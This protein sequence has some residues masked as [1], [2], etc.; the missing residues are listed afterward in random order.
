MSTSL[1]RTAQTE[2]RNARDRLLD[3]ASNLLSERDNLEVSL[4][5]ISRRSG[6]N[7]G[8]VNYYFGGKEGLLTALL[9]R[10][11]L[12]SLEGL[13]RL[14]ASDLPPETKLE[15]HIRGVMQTYFRFPYINRLINHLQSESSESAEVLARMF[16]SPLQVLQNR[17]VEEGVAA[18]CFR[19]V[20]PW[21]LYHALI[22]MCEFIFQSRNTLPHLDGA[23]PLTPETCAEYARHI[24][25]L[26]TKGIEREHG[27]A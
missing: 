26:V 20:D 27:K 12:A 4:S 19:T 17:I 22:G 5:E 21:F 23:R 15:R 6:L 18:G 9:E 25:E 8:L 13:G 16:I 10:D 14:V 3:A 1:R 2:K 24:F 7:H 11:A